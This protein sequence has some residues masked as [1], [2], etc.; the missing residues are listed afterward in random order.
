MIAFGEQLFDTLFQG[1]VRGCT[2]KRAPRQGRKLDFIF[3][4]MIPWIAESPGS[5][6]R[7]VRILPCDRKTRFSAMF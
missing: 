5:S 7:P 2:T 1:G 4:S 3:T 6:L